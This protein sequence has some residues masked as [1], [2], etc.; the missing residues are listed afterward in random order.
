MFVHLD[1]CLFFLALAVYVRTQYIARERAVTTTS[2]FTVDAT[3]KPVRFRFRRGR[4]QL[5]NK[6]LFYFRGRSF[7]WLELFTGEKSRTATDLI[8]ILGIYP[9]LRGRDWRDTVRFSRTERAADYR[10]QLHASPSC[11]RGRATETKHARQTRLYHTQPRRPDTGPRRLF[12]RDR[13]LRA[14]DAPHR[15]DGIGKLKACVVTRAVIGGYVMGR[16]LS[17]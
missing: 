9:F 5:S 15:S 2:L 1:F 3:L 8:N 6:R 7:T 17:Y 16:G 11:N 4:F 10:K 14:S 13:A 12:E